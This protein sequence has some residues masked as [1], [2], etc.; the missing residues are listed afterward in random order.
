[1]LSINDEL[2]SKLTDLNGAIAKKYSPIFSNNFDMKIFLEQNI[3]TIVNLEK[4]SE[5]ELSKIKE[6]GGLVAVD[7]STNRK[8]GSFP[9]YIELYQG[10]AKSTN[11]DVEDV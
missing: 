1:M 11:Q 7:G 5:K 4:L 8:G 10:L 3:G 9:H 6:K 2:K